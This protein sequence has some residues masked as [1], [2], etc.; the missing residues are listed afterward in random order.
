MRLE[1]EAVFVESVKNERWMEYERGKREE[2]RKGEV[3]E[4]EIEGRR[5]GMRKEQRRSLVLEKIEER[6]KREEEDGEKKGVGEGK[7]MKGFR[8]ARLLATLLEEKYEK[9]K[10]QGREIE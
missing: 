8:A 10:S 2:E 3:M 5:E 6:I 4:K 9:V 7:E 1:R